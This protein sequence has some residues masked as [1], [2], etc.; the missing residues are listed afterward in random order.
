MLKRKHS[1][2]MTIS[3][4]LLSYNRMMMSTDYMSSVF[5]K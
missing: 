5:K 4:T 2:S 1:S 3:D